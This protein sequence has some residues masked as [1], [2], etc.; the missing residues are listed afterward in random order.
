MTIPLHTMF[1]PKPP[2]QPM[3][4]HP[5]P[6]SA[7]KVHPKGPLQVVTYLPLPSH[8]TL[9]T[10]RCLLLLQGKAQIPRGGTWAPYDPGLSP[11]HGGSV[12][13]DPGTPWS[14]FSVSTSGYVRSLPHPPWPNFSPFKAQLGGQP[15]TG[16]PQCPVCSSWRPHDA[17]SDPPGTSREEPHELSHRGGP[18]PAPP[19]AGA[20]LHLPSQCTCSIGNHSEVTG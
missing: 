3:V 8:C 19:H 4:Y 2:S 11:H 6:Y 14:V 7:R 15:S 17:L 1:C 12:R 13:S 5:K 16:P 10:I 9:S 20:H 18:S